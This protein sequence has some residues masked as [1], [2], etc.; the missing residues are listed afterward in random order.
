MPTVTASRLGVD[1]TTITFDASQ[2]TLML[3]V[4]R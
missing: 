2:V 4:A 3:R 1:M